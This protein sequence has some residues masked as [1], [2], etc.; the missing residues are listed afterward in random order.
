[1]LLTIT[2]ATIDEIS[3]G[4]FILGMGVGT[5]R[6]LSSEGIIRSHPLIRLE[7]YVLLMR[8]LWNGETVSFNGKALEVSQVKLDFKPFRNNI[9]IYI[10]ATEERGL[11][12]AANIAN[13]I[14]LNG[15]TP[16]S[17]AMSV[18][19]IVGSNSKVSV[20]GN[21]MVSMDQDEE[22]AIEGA[23]LLA[24]TYLTSIPTIANANAISHDFIEELKALEKKQ[25]ASTAMIHLPDRMIKNAV[26]V[27]TPEQCKKWILDYS[28]SGP[29][30]VLVT[31]IHGNTRQ[32]IHQV[33]ELFTI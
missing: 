28:Q 6:Y 26:A 25:G 1:M 2:A 16:K 15:Y 18:K 4:R 20:L 33:A 13:G 5:K 31:R 27:G 23:R 30:E 3:K 9:P 12:F 17:H 29:D 22:K 19:E 24:Y 8:R 21:V 32:I 11:R 7:E 14:I 10:G